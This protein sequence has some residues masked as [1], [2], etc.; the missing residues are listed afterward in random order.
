[1]NTTAK[2]PAIIGKMGKYTPAEADAMLE[3]AARRLGGK[4][5]RNGDMARV[6]I[7]EFRGE[8]KAFIELDTVPGMG[9]GLYLR[10]K[11]A[12][13]WKRRA[14][15]SLRFMLKEKGIEA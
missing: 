4:V 11:R 13:M 5:W 8:G 1:M 6:Y 3:E 12:G 14:E 15:E 7:N 2:F 9:T 10:V